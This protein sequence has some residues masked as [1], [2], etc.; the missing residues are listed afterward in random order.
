MGDE[1]LQSSPLGMVDQSQTDSLLQSLESGD[2]VVRECDPVL[3]TKCLY[4][5]AA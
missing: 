3:L 4:G 2:A 1:G 5:P